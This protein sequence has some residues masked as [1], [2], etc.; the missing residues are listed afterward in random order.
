MVAEN[1]SL[2]VGIVI[3]N[4]YTKGIF[5]KFMK[6]IANKNFPEAD[7]HLARCHILDSTLKAISSWKAI[8]MIE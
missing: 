4:E 6:E 5:H 1:M 2:A 7:K 8:K 3:A